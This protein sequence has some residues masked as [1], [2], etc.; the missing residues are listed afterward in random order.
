MTAFAAVIGL[1]LGS[2]ANVLA[3]RIPRGE[4]IV[5]P[6]SHCPACGHRIRPPDNIPIVSYVLLRGRCR[7]CRAPISPKYPAV[8]AAVGALTALAA[9]RYGVSLETA[10]ATALATLL[11]ALTVT[12][13]ELRILPDRLTLTGA[14]LGIAFALAG[15]C[16]LPIAACAVRTAPYLLASAGAFALFALI[17]AAARGGMG[18]GDAKMA[19]MIGAFLGWPKTGSALLV[20][21]LVGGTVAV[22]LV[23]LGIKTRKDLIPFGPFLALGAAVAML[24][25]D[26]VIH[27]ILSVSRG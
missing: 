5:F 2:F 23:A 25:G 19:A 20:A 14:A 27:V 16:R 12:D 6:W 4:S 24:W 26:A 3:H 15:S 13:L 11:A 17:A 10:K 21:F 22:L 8:E 7:D 9:A 1:F 18:G